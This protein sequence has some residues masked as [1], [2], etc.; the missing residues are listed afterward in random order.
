M[1]QIWLTFLSLCTPSS[2]GGPPLKTTSLVSTVA[3]PCADKNTVF[4]AQKE[5]CG[6]MTVFIVR[7]H[8]SLRYHLTE[9]LGVG[10]NNPP[11][12]NN[13]ILMFT[14]T[15]FLVMKIPTWQ[16]LRKYMVNKNRILVYNLYLRDLGILSYT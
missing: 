1:P 7:D 14:T 15:F 13:F 3:F 2:E 4:H 10:E 9:V 6:V 12:F 11:A 16:L 5:A 8:L